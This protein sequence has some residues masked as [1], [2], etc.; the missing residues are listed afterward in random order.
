MLWSTRLHLP[1]GAMNPN[2]Q[3]K[4]NYR[5]QRE[6]APAVIKAKCQRTVPP[7]HLP[8]CPVSNPSLKHR[9][10]SLSQRPLSRHM[11]T[12]KLHTDVL[13]HPPSITHQFHGQLTLF[14]PVCLYMDISFPDQRRSVTSVILQRL[15]KQHN[16]NGGV[17][18]MLV[19]IPCFTLNGEPPGDLR[20]QEAV[21]V[22]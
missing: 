3:L 4:G 19:F 9:R 18:M 20:P 13:T 14:Q 17:T 12:N 8:R 16:R 2:C 1:D 7:P 21:M 11:S 6:Q 10:V 5:Q 22:S 15:L